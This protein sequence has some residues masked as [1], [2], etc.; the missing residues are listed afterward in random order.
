MMLELVPGDG[1]VPQ[2]FTADDDVAHGVIVV[3][4]TDIFGETVRVKG[5]C[6]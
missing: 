4:A 5:K 2:R 3:G 6:E 1:A